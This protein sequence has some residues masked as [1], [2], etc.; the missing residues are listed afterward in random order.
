MAVPEKSQRL[1]VGFAGPFF[2]ADHLG[3]GVRAWRVTAVET[4]VEENY[5]PAL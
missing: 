2:R 4:W 3:G 1:W 5:V